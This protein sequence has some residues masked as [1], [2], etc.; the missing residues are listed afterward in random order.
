MYA[1]AMRLLGSAEEKTTKERNR[2][3]VPN[4][5]KTA[6]TLVHCNIVNSKYQRNSQVL[7]I[8]V[9]N[10]S[11]GQLFN[12]LSKNHTYTETFRSEFP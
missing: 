8:F 9:P 12:I 5:E 4:L 7:S 6:V 3:N 1:T 10:K 11:F 2:E